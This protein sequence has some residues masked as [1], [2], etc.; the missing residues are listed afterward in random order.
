MTAP[1]VP[2]GPG[3]WWRNVN[4]DPEAVCCVERETAIPQR[5]GLV[6]WIAGETDDV[7]RWVED[8]GRWLCAVPSPEATA[9]QAAEVEALRV[10]VGRL[11]KE[12]DAM[13]A[14]LQTLAHIQGNPKIGAWETTCAR[15]A[16][17][18][19]DANGDRADV[20]AWCCDEPGDYGVRV[21]KP[22]REQ[23]DFRAGNSGKL[24]RA[25][26]LRVL[27]GWGV[28]VSNALEVSDG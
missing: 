10:E 12:R 4:G 24:G 27:A 21:W 16:V 8:D 11:T 26:V 13:A 20:A 18:Y 2:T 6:F 28:N 9:A 5:S 7:D 15:S 17:Y 19:I 25:I 1:V 22:G 23:P 3:W 14:H